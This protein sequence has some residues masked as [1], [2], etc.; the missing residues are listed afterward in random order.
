[1]N[2]HTPT[3]E[4]YIKN[5]R[6][7]SVFYEKKKQTFSSQTRNVLD[8]KIMFHCGKFKMIELLIIQVWL[9]SEK[10]CRRWEKFEIWLKKTHPAS[11]M[12]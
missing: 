4:A 12:R 9:C 6:F 7:A 3:K 2:A 10:L 5:N 11:K 1:M 8:E